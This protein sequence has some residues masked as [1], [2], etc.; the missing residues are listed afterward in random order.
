MSL[1]T[2]N[3]SRDVDKKRKNN[4]LNLLSSYINSAGKIVAAGILTLF[5]FSVLAKEYSIRSAEES[6]MLTLDPGDRVVLEE[7]VWVDQSL[8][9]KGAGTAENPILLTVENPG[10]V[11]LTGSSSLVIDGVWL[12]VDGLSFKE[13]YTLKEN[14]ISF[15]EQSA[16][17]RLTNTSIIDYNNPDVKVR[18]SWVV[19]YGIKNRMDHCYIKGK[20]HVGTTIGVYVSDQP[21]YH[22]IDHNYFDGRPPLGRNGGEIIRMGTDQWSM[23]DSFTTVEENIFTHCDGEIEIVSNKST[24]NT[25]RNN[26]FYESAGMLTLRHGNKA[27]VHGNYFIGNQKE[28]TGGIRIIGEEHNIYNN[29]LYGLTGTG[30]NAGITFMNAWKNPPLYGY[31][32]VKNVEVKNNTI[33]ACRESIVVGSGKNAKTILPP[34]NTLVSNNIIITQTP[35]ITWTEPA[36]KHPRNIKFENNVAYGMAKEDYPQGIE[37]E[38]PKLELNTLGLYEQKEGDRK[39]GAQ[40]AAEISIKLFHAKD[41]GPSW[42]SLEREFQIK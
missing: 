38:D 36:A 10:S 16:H 33:I 9:F 6:R 11:V 21:N 20:T 5:S 41:I 13:G 34:L 31:W 14:V 28:G 19:L 37:I 26:L 18:N 40:V 8:I 7:G 32:Q 24:N 15:S 23:H 42:M 2:G 29:Y 35:L 25:I 1:L 30:L 27:R 22:R 4:I 17:C 39:I 3:L 12:I